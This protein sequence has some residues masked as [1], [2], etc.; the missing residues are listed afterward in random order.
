MARR[1]PSG[2]EEEL[3]LNL[4][5][6]IDVV[7]NLV[8]FFMIVIDMSQKELEVLTLPFSAKAIP[9]KGKEDE[10]RVI[11][12]LEIDAPLKD[13]DLYPEINDGRVKIKIKGRE[14]DLTSLKK[15]MFDHAERKRDLTDPN[16]PS[17]I[18]VLIRCDKRIRW[19]EVQWIMQACADPAV[20]IYKLQFATSESPTE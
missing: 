1:I 20:R 13:Q 15:E 8:V 11:V 3:E 4:T 14:Y 16:E 17:E 12:N 19:R 18:Y 6:M 7:F 2:A 9:D 10:L 5:P